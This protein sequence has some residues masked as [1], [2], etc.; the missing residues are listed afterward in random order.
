MTTA[1]ASLNSMAALEHELA[2]LRRSLVT[3]AV[4]GRLTDPDCLRVFMSNHAF[5]V[6]DF[7]SLLKSLQG[8]L[9]GIR[10][11]WIPPGD[12]LAARLVNE[13]V[14]GEETDEIAPGKYIS[15]FDLYLESMGEVGADSRPIRQFIAAMREEIP[16]GAA[17]ARLSIPDETR[18]F[19]ET[20]MRF[21]EAGTVEAAAAFLLGREDLVP[22]MFRPMIE[23]LTRAGVKCATYR[24]Y[25]ERHVHLDE[26]QHGPMAKRLLEGLCGA[27]PAKWRAAAGAAT[28]ALEA[29]RALWDGVLRAMG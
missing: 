18:R 25:L 6:W 12:A 27:D 17:L 23:S 16:P 5:A 3:H 11:P 19:V 21:C 1:T 15:H 20:T 9:T 7:M 28:Q 22:A 10:V 2:P 8:R 14:L 4:Y 29:R 13:I 24:L 26:E